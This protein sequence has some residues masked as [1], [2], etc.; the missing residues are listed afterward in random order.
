MIAPC[1]RRAFSL[2]LAGTLAAWS[3]R[4]AG[5]ANR[6]AGLVYVGMHGNQI[7]AARFDPAT[8]NL[9]LIGPAADM[10]SPTWT[11]VHP[12]LPVVFADSELGNDGK[13]DGAVFSFRADRAT[14]KLDQ[15]GRVDAGGGGTTYLWLDAP[16]MTLL[17]TNYGSGSVATIPVTADGGL[18]PVVSLIAETGSGPSPRQRSSHAHSVV[19]DPS[20]RFALV[21]DLG[22]D[23]VFVYPFDRAAHALEPDPSGQER[24]Y[25]AA[26]GSGPRHLAFHPNGRALYLYCEL[27][28]DLQ[29]LR[30]DAAEGRLALTQTVSTNSA[31]FAGKSA[32]AEVAVSR[33]G[34]FVYASNRGE[35]TLVVYGAA[36]DG[37]ELTFL[38]RLPGIGDPWSFALHPNGRWLLVANEHTNSVAVYGVEP[39]SG[40]LTETGRSIATPNPVCI[41]FL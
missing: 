2:G 16:S 11:V 10:P 23:R 15:I 36:R 13:S 17:A 3:P 14:G 40:R 30:W 12:S 31:G 21:A 8:G 26:P 1:S 32:A 5:A 6:S 37:G 25:A 18:S 24:H 34:R 9:A 41:S 19:V 7:T 4:P 27:T 38:Q 39:S 33:D 22:A 28:A 35:N 20:G 29:V